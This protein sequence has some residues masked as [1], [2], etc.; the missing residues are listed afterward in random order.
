MNYYI[1]LL[2]GH[3]LPLLLLRQ[4]VVQVQ[5]WFV[6]APFWCRWV[7]ILKHSFFIYRISNQFDFC[8]QNWRT[9][10][11][12]SPNA[13][14]PPPP[15]LLAITSIFR[16]VDLSKKFAFSSSMTRSTARMK[17]HRIQ[18]TL[19]GSLRPIF[20]QTAARTRQQHRA[21]CDNKRQL[22]RNWF[23]DWFFVNKSLL[24]KCC[25]HTGYEMKKRFFSLY[26]PLPTFKMQATLGISI[27][28]S[29]GHRRQ[30]QDDGDENYFSPFDAWIAF[31]SLT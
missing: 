19:L 17:M 21:Q 30:Y 5:G 29:R 31:P 25:F 11:E 22:N 16:L 27:K 13:D 6:S 7:C 2:P 9:C 4:P 15:L 24:H 23:V 18:A 1:V 3:C 20:R 10:D 8:V 26:P 14:A 28:P 12:S